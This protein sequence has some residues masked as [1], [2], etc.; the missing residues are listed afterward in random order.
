VTG[1]VLG[2]RLSARDRTYLKAYGKLILCERRRP[3]EER[4][5]RRRRLAD[6]S[7]PVPR[8]MDDSLTRPL[9]DPRVA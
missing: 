2:R 8:Q 3:E 6:G 5:L 4:E 9:H 1:E 7:Y